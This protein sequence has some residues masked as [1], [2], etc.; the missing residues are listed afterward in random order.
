MT[1]LSDKFTTKILFP[2]EVR[3]ERLFITCARLCRV[4]Y[5]PDKNKLQNTHIKLMHDKEIGL[6]DSYFK[7]KRSNEHQEHSF[8]L[9]DEADMDQQELEK[10]HKANDLRYSVTVSKSGYMFV[11]YRGT[12]TFKNWM[13]N[14]NN[15]MQVSNYMK[16]NE[17]DYH[18]GEES[19]PDSEADPSM[20]E[21]GRARQK[22]VKTDKTVQ[23]HAG[24]YDMTRDGRKPIV[25]MIK[26][27]KDF[28]E[29]II[30]TGH[31][32]GGG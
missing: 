4:I 16:E 11:C 24:F 14:L 30:F 12:K 2:G 19:E 8:Y 29:T 22:L 32:L 3:T 9:Y 21:N 20:F 1:S 13:K 18:D 23:I 25:D 27:N 17:D 28:L 31:S 7:R 5:W 15:K 10:E 6:G 26:K